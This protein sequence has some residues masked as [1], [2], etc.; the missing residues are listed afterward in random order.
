MA[1]RD[2]LAKALDELAELQRAGPSAAGMER[3]RSYLRDKSPHAVNKAVKVARKWGAS[4]LAG[5]LAGV[6]ER[7]MGSADPG[8]EIKAAV[9]EALCEWMASEGRGVFEKGITHRQ[10]E[11]IHVPPWRVDVAAGL[12]GWCALGLVAIGHADQVRLI[13]PLLTDE[14]RDPR[15]FGARAL[16][17][18]GVEAAEMLLRLKAL[19]GDRE[20]EVTAECLSGLARGWP[21][22]SVEFIT[23]R[24]EHEPSR[25]GALLALAEC[26][27][28]R[29]LPVLTTAYDRERDG[30]RK[31]DVLDAIALCRRNEAVDWVIGLIETG[32]AMEASAAVEAMAPRKHEPAVWG[33]VERAAGAR[34][35]NP[36]PGSGRIVRGGQ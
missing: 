34:G 2:P 24:L 25:R 12:R 18:A 19:Q 1:K 15:A 33:R 5:E 7:A 29:A 10:H 28:P 36:N 20:E 23:S 9:A 4:E 13:L 11:P 27:S 21:E 3:L 30:E 22:R 35:V 14:E 16:S 26:R 6:F 17:Q 32:S 31:R 8:C